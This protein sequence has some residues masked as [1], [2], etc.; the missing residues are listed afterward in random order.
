MT[1]SRKLAYV[2][3]KIA[4]IEITRTKNK[5]KKTKPLSEQHGFG[6][7]FNIREIE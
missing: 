7:P 1:L 2:E 3:I 4:E 6:D 5:N